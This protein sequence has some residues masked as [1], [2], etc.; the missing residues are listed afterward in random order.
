MLLPSHLLNE[1]FVSGVHFERFGEAFFPINQLLELL[2]LVAVFKA[3][4][5]RLIVNVHHDLEELIPELRNF[6]V[7]DCADAEYKLQLLS[8]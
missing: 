5:P 1:A 6:E 3:V 7:A 2:L 8:E 4:C